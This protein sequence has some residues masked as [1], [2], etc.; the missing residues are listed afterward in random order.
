MDMR[1]ISLGAG[2]WEQGSSSHAVLIQELAQTER[3][4][5]TQLNLMGLERCRR[6]LKMSH[7][8]WIELVETSPSVSIVGL[9]TV[10]PV[11]L[12]HWLATARNL[13]FGTQGRKSL[14]KL[15]SQIRNRD[16][17]AFLVQSHS[18]SILSL[19]N[20]SKDQQIQMF[21]SDEIGIV[22]HTLCCI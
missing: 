22:G 17:V 1:F 16:T 15:I 20:T 8:P 19:K 11:F 18:C 4:N 3:L 10:L 6:T 7:Y 9:L 12:S 14:L 13:P 21:S 2:R 5:W